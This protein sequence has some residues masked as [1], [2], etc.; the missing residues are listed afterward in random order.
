MMMPHLKERRS[1]GGR[2]SEWKVIRVENGVETLSAGLCVSPR[3]RERER[4]REGEER[5]EKGHKSNE[6]LVL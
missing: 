4:E 6:D 5:G 2:G 1:E 3:Q